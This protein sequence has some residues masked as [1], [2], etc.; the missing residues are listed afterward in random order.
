MVNV[1]PLELRLHF[2]EWTVGKRKQQE[3]PVSVGWV[4]EGNESECTEL[5]E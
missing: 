4:V 5:D 3:N 2:V 1:P